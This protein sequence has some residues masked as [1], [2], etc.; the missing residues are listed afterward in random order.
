MI[1]DFDAVNAVL[2]DLV[3]PPRIPRA[4]YRLQ[5]N[6]GFTFQD[7]QALIPYLRAL[8]ISDLYASPLFK[9]RPGSTHGYDVVDYNQFN[10]ALGT[11]EDFDALAA[12]LSEQGMGLLLDMVPNHMGVSTE[13]IWWTD[14]LKEGP[15]SRYG[16]YFDIAWRPQNRALDDRVLLP[17]L[18]D[19]YGQ[20][21]E[22]GELKVVY[23]HGDFYVHYYEHQFPMTPESYRRILA[24][25]MEMLPPDLNEAEAWVPLE[26]ASVVRSLDYLPAYTTTE[27]EAIATRRREETIV[28][29]RLLGLFDKSERFR[30]TMQAALDRLNGSPGDPAS[31]DDLDALLAEQP[32][33][34]A[35]WRVATDEINY[36]RF[37]DV[38]DMAAIRVEDEQVFADVHQLA[39]RLLAEGK[40]S[41]LRIDHP[42]G[43]WDPEGYFWRLQSGYIEAALRRRLRDDTGYAGLVTAR[44]ETLRQAQNRQIEWPLYVLVEKILSEAEPLPERWAVYGTTGYDFLYAVNNLFVDPA[45]E[46]AFSALY[47]DFIGAAIALHD[48]ADYTKKLVMAQSLTSEIDARSAELARI[49]EQNRRWRGFTRNSLAFGLSEFIAALDIYRTYITGPGDISERDRVYVEAAIAR[50]RQR[51]PLVPTSI[52]DFLRATLLMENF[53]QFAED[54]RAD[55]REFVMKF[56]QI[57]GPVMAKSMEDTAFY[58]YN[59]LVS[60]NEVGGHLDRFGATVEEFHAHNTDRAFPYTMLST[61]THDTKRSEDVRARLNVLS[62]VPDDWRA[63]INQWA[64]INAAA[65]RIVGGQPAPSRNDEYLLYQTLLGV[66]QPGMDEDATIQQRVSAYML[67][68][69]NE[70]KTHSNWVNPND[71]YARAVTDFLGDIWNNRAFR[72]SFDPFQQRIAYFGRF[73]ALAQTLLKLTS[74]GIPDIYQ[75]TELWD[76]S[77]VDPD[78]RRPVDFERR[79]QMLDQIKAQEGTDRLKLARDLL[80]DAPDGAIKLYLIYR[81]LNYRARHEALFRDGAYLPL[82][83]EGARAGHVCAFIRS[84]G[85]GAALTVVPRL[86]LTLT[87]GQQR[88]PT[89]AGVWQDTRLL[90][91]EAVAGKSL[92]NLLTGERAGGQTSVALAQALAEWPVGLFEISG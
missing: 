41:G 69:I 52:F 87:G 22:A 6:A 23:W 54:Q 78:N 4:T 20:A 40:V 5:F 39:L 36:R 10:P 9:P 81:A 67:K 92:E 56:Q 44:L 13:N 66:Y 32:Y 11:A 72:A 3:R 79:Q 8:G 17:V 35:Y 43:L 34:L 64:S 45:A 28:R 76:Y 42:D 47:S 27:P 26:L 80:E 57:T 70:A 14:V 63:L 37:F 38:N 59:R 71:A 60:L 25:V 86:P 33:R 30:T 21:L 58:I 74:P 68:A 53:S 1:A 75:G 51:N 90:L 91:P 82:K 50:A 7:A 88:P 18:G 61:S 16:R 31:F 49:V 73:N 62:E 29:W 77:L 15:S 48:L 89:G 84:G 83:V 65:R 12:A 24:F 55:L 85:G 2:D 19:H 46:E